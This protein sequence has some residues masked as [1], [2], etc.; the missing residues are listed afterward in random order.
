MLMYDLGVAL[1]ASREVLETQIITKT[2]GG[3]GSR[4]RRVTYLVSM[5]E[6]A[7]SIG[8]SDWTRQPII[9]TPRVQAKGQCSL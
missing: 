9:M 6:K 5:C 3:D 7:R 1:Q 4:L 2:C 8:T